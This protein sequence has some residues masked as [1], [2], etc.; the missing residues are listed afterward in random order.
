LP[1]LRPHWPIWAGSATLPAA[2]TFRCREDISQP[3]L[4]DLTAPNSFRHLSVIR[5][6]AKRPLRKHHLAVDDDLEVPVRAL[7]EG[8]RG[9]KLSV[10]FGRQPGGPRLIVS[11]H[12][13]FDR[14]IHHAST[15]D[16]QILP[17]PNSSF[18]LLRRAWCHP[19]HFLD[20][21][22]RMLATPPG[23]TMRSV[24]P[25]SSR[26]QSAPDWLWSR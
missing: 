11:N 10:Q 23:Q 15:L 8:G 22:R 25:V 5:K 24:V 7:D 1:T 17:E 14:N 4:K 16:H 12:A 2:P 3:L 20:S 13:V 26:R 6:S 9:R 21:S 19:S 18:V